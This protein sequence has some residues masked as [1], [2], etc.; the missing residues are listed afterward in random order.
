[1]GK[2]TKQMQPKHAETLSPWLKDFVSSACSTP[3]PLLPDHLS[4]FPT[5]WPFPR[6]DLYHWIPLLNRFDDI[7][8]CF[9]A[10]YNLDQGP[11]NRDF[12]CDLLLNRGTK[13]ES[14]GEQTWDTESLSKLGY[15]EDGDR[16]LVEAILK[17]TR[18]LLEHCGNRS[19]Y[20]SSMVLNKL[21]NTTVLS[22]LLATLQVSA[23]LA[24]RYQASVKRIGSA[25]RT[26]STAL[27]GNHYQID[28]DRV[29]SLAQP[30][31]KT[32]IIS[33]SDS[34]AAATPTSSTKGKEKAHATNQKNAAAMF[35]NDL[36]AVLT[37]D[38]AR[39][40]GWGDVKIT[41]MAPSTAKDQPA[42]AASDRVAS[43]MPSTPTPLRRSTTAGSQHN[44]PRSARQSGAEDTSPLSVR[45]PGNFNEQV[46]PSHRTF[47][48]PQ[49]ILASTPIYELL[50]RCP[51][52]MPASTRY[53]VLNRLRVAKALL[54]DA[55]TRQQAL[56]VRLLAITNLAY[57]HPEST[58]IEKVLRHDN[59]ETRRYQ[60]VYQLA[61]L[62]HPP[63][64]GSIQ[65]P[66]WLQS[67]VLALL[68][69]ISNYAARYQDVLSALNAN[70]NHGILLYVIRKAVAGMKTDEPDRGIH[71]TEVDQWRTNLFSLTT[72]L[73]MSTRIGAE[74]V[75]AGLMDILVEILKIRSDVAQRNQSMILAFIDGLI[76]S[77]QNAF[78]T[79]FS[80]S[81][82]DAISD[83][84][85][86]TVAES[87]QLVESGQ[88][89]KPEQMCQ[90]VDYEIPYNQQQTLKWV[91]K[92]VHHMMTNSY[93]YGGN[94]DR[95]L[96]NLVDKSEL[97]G[98]LRDIMQNTK[99]FGSVLWTNTVTVLSDFINN[100][101]TSF[102]AISESG[103]IVTYLEAITG[104][105]VVP[106]TAI[107][108][109]QESEEQ[110]RDNAEAQ[111]ADDGDHEGSRDDN[112]DESSPDI[113]DASV[114]IEAD[115]RPHP[116]PKT[117]WLHPTTPAR[118]REA[119]CQPLTPSTL[120]RRSLTPFV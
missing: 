75:T 91:L 17:F 61:E 58:F 47:E 36:G 46:N 110:T 78:Q 66:L 43:S 39:W 83:L 105:P 44:T 4:K 56:A 14:Y 16:Q 93:S 70:V 52:D 28:L 57:I 82:L 22:V 62:I 64:D 112:D 94:T 29:Q 53:E 67:I 88:G 27:L 23:E 24:Q 102:A 79:F 99:R 100:D 3:L 13:T 107:P 34:A 92:F 89:N 84:L 74:M 50:S 73:A 119:F 108:P 54:S 68:E 109:P 5:R 45:S 7:L 71:N 101:P 2:I 106:Q 41:Y 6:G 111:T 9:S 11:Q 8:D 98:S 15:Q 32:P 49:S 60:L 113:S 120:S 19:I 72:H 59:D 90:V 12:G 18:T 35:A 97:L 86:T 85:V 80:G 63:A 25:S 33:L 65:V 81:G 42:P 115:T 77:Y 1:M 48:L 55:E 69:V 26:V 103:M 114:Q 31:S 20:S 117:S 51:A 40:N 30:F 104:R 38:N 96:R 76:W 21:L 118:W 116:P 37:S 95:L 87:K 10:T